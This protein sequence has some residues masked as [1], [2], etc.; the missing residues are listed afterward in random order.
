MAARKQNGLHP[1]IPHIFEIIGN[2][3]L[4]GMER[5]VENLIRTLPPGQFRVTCL[6]PFESRF[7]S[8]LRGLGCELFIAPL[9]DEPPWR[10]IQLATEVIRQQHIDLIHAHMPKAHVLAGL[11][12]CL[13]QTPV[14]ATVHGMNITSHEL[15]ICRTVGSRLIVVC[16]EAYTQALA[17]GVPPER[18]TLIANGVDTEIFT[19]ARDGARFRAAIG[20]PDG[21]PLVG[22]VGRIAPE[23][24]PDQFVRAA[25]YVCQR[26]PDVHFVLVGDGH[27]AEADEIASMIQQMGI[28]DRVHMAG[29]WQD[30]AEVYPALDIVAQTSRSEGMPLA[31][32]EAMACARPIVAIAVGGVPEIVEV[33]VTGWL[34]GPHD[35]QAVGQILLTA[36]AHPEQLPQIGQAA[37]QRAEERFNLRASVRLTADLFQEL[38][39]AAQPH[40][41]VDWTSWPTAPVPFDRSSHSS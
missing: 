2:A 37:R 41:A 28:G 4:G 6:C 22:Y 8:R 7:T 40:H 13:T 18:L 10:S 31:L 20:V 29:L 33:G 27:L 14:V 11:A 34:A 21:A 19:P 23:K 38:I 35:W 24:G 16:Q 39:R 26:R 25:Q 36:L 12:G 15:G 3:A 1:R 5:Y 32:L 30:V 9:H 17:M